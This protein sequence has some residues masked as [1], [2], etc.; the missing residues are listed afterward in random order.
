MSSSQHRVLVSAASSMRLALLVS[1]LLAPSLIL[2]MRA[3]GTSTTVQDKLV[4]LSDFC[5]GPDGGL[6]EWSV[7]AA[8][9]GF[10]AAIAVYSQSGWDAATSAN[11]NCTCKQDLTLKGYVDPFP[12]GETSSGQMIGVTSPTY[13]FV[14][15]LT[16]AEPTSV[17][18]KVH[19]ERSTSGGAVTGS[20]PEIPYDALGLLETYSVATGVCVGLLLTMA[21]VNS[22][23]SQKHWYLTPPPVKFLALSVAMWLADGACMTVHFVLFSRDGYGQPNV[24]GFARVVEVMGRLSFMGLLLLIAKGYAVQTTSLTL[25]NRCSTVM[26]IGILAGIYGI[27]AVWYLVNRTPG[28]VNYAYDSTSGLTV[29]VAQAITG[30]WFAIECFISWRREKRAF[31]KA[32]LRTFGLAFSFYFACFPVAVL[33]AYLYL[34]EYEDEKAVEI[35]LQAA[36]IIFYALMLHMMMPLKAERVFTMWQPDN[37]VVKLLRPEISSVDLLTPVLSGYSTPSGLGRQTSTGSN[38]S[39]G[40]RSGS[41]TPKRQGGYGTAAGGST[42]PTYNS[43]GNNGSSSAPIS[44]SSMASGY[45]TPG[46]GETVIRIEA[47]GAGGGSRV[48]SAGGSDKRRSKK[49]LSSRSSSSSRINTGTSAAAATAAGTGVSSAVASQQQALF[50]G[51]H[52]SSYSFSGHVHDG[53]GGHRE[54]D[55]LL[56]SGGGAYDRIDVDDHHHG[57]MRGGHDAGNSNGSGTAIMGGYDERRINVEGQHGSG[58]RVD[59]RRHNT[60]TQHGRSH[61]N[62]GGDDG[63][64]GDDDVA[65]A[66]D[67]AISSMGAVVAH[68]SFTEMDTPHASHSQQAHGTSA[69]SPGRGGGGGGQGQRDH[70]HQP[71]ERQ[72]SSAA[73]AGILMSQ[74]LVSTSSPP[75]SPGLHGHGH[76]RE[77]T[78]T[79]SLLH[80]NSHGR[81]PSGSAATGPGQH[82]EHGTGGDDYDLL[83]LDAHAAGT[84]AGS[85]RERA[86]SHHRARKSSRAPIT[87]GSMAMGSVSKVK[88]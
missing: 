39:K 67:E 36:R 79:M 51:N 60:M 80:A 63:G 14:A 29:C 26:N 21:C 87:T 25:R 33:V 19:F 72:D 74:Y 9:D 54:T 84:G 61:G 3:D 37:H 83:Q 58:D 8:S 56:G 50:A 5:Y 62:D 47:S 73:L 77:R 52:A 41:R 81:S 86:H 40:S 38:K 70:A 53:G 22:W 68:A 57:V 23:W 46:N 4:Y 48:A 78:R 24:E 28:D 45:G 59:K 88:R 31:Q 82:Q 49:G 7:D 30:V 11:C 20:W 16:C 85:N 65:Y 15:L 32:W 55:S 71:V 1:L 17:A 12:A 13:V 34:P 69:S 10:G 75:G 27:M 42:T 44:N 64:D 43:G 35:T 18:W 66:A 76:A 2:A 6:L